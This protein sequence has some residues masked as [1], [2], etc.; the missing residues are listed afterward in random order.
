MHQTVNVFLIP[1]A[2]ASANI[3]SKWKSSLP[4]WIRPIPITLPGRGIRYSEPLLT[5]WPDLLSLLVQEM[6]PFT[7]QPFAI[8]GHSLG[9]LIAYE[10]AHTMHRNTGAL[11]IWLGFAGCVAPCC[12]RPNERWKDL[13]DSNIIEEVKC[14]GGTPLEVLGHP[15]LVALLLPVLRAD[16]TLAATYSYRK[17]PLL[18]ANTLILNGLHDQEVMTLPNCVPEW[19]AETS[20]KCSIEFLDAGHFF[21]ESHHDEVIKM[22]VTSLSDTLC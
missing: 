8:F 10:L 16:F 9:A 1:H 2:G 13:S 14:L 19:R 21:L 3:F 5:T 6:Q 20:G 22:I 18:K 15:E 17:R 12:W 7:A 11:P 4:A